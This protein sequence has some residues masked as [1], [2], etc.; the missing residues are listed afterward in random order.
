MCLTFYHTIPC[1]CLTFY[2]T[3]PCMCLTFYHSPLYVFNL[4]SHNPVFIRPLTRRL[5][6]ILQGKKHRKP[7]FLPNCQC[8]YPFIDKSLNFCHTSCHLQV[9]LTHYQTTNFRL[10][11]TERVCR[12]QFQI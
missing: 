9:L 11:Q 3:V 8:F 12:Q 10:F 1:M 6:K 4:L 5:L 7:A 2:H